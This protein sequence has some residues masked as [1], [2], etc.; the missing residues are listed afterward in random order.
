MMGRHYDQ[1]YSGTVL[2]TDDKRKGSHIVQYDDGQDVYEW[3]QK[4]P[5]NRKLQEFAPLNDFKR[6]PKPREVS[7][8]SSEDEDFE[9]DDFIPTEDDETD[10]ISTD[11]EF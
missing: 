3:L 4:V 2:P 7:S 11:D 1:H 5:K 9:D 8:A 6:H 10:S